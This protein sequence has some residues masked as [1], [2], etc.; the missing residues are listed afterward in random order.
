M[1]LSTSSSPL[2]RIIV[3]LTAKVIVSPSLAIT[4]ALRSDPGPPSFVFVTTMVS[5]RSAIIAAKNGSTK[6]AN[7]ILDVILFFTQVLY[8]ALSSPIS[9][10]ISF[11]HDQGRGGGLGRIAAIGGLVGGG[12]VVSG[13]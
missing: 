7:L 6:L 9:L 11:S 1:L 12:V 3:P 5:A 4:S 2:V 8:V 13:Y 10:A